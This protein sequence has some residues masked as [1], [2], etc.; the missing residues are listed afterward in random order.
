MRRLVSAV[1][2]LTPFAEKTKI[3]RKIKFPFDL[4]A[5]E[6]FTEDLQQKMRPANRKLMEIEKNRDER[7]KVAKRTKKD[8]DPLLKED[9]SEEKAKRKAEAE[10][11]EQLVDPSLKQ[12]EGASTTGLYELV[13]VVTHKGQSSDGGH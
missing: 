13:G 1:A 12:D 7:A 4:D 11:I 5:T 9:D 3:M 2:M 10:E 8:N 6:L